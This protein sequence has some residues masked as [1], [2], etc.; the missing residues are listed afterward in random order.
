M[1]F[2]FFVFLLLLPFLLI[3]QNNAPAFETFSLGINYQSNINRNDFHN[4]WLADAG[5]EGYFSTPFYFGQAQFGL[6]YTSYS[7]KSDEQPDFTSLLIYLQWGYEFNLPA[8]LSLALYTSAGLYQMNFDDFNLEIDPG[9][10]SERELSMGLNT[11][12][13]YS[14]YNDWKLNLQLSYIHV[15]THKKIELINIGFGISKTFSSPQWFKDFF[16]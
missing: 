1:K 6:I 13:R 15:F 5:I 14:F 16:N 3:A 7:A 4:Y 11:A 12:M 10:L 2:H 8:N 9:L